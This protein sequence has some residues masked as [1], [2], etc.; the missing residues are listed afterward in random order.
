MLLGGLVSTS[1]M[2]PL[3]SADEYNKKTVLTVEEPT[4]IDEVVLQPGQ[5]VLRLLDERTD[6]HVVQIFNRDETHMI[7][8]VV[9]I[10]TERLQQTSK[11]TFAFYE[12]P[13][14]TVKALRVWYYPGDN[15]G[16]EFSYPKHLQAAAGAISAQAIA[17]A[18]AEPAPSAVEQ[19]QPQPSQ[20]AD[21]QAEP[22]TP[23]PQPT[24]QT[25]VAQNSAPSAD[26]IPVPATL[27][28]ELPQTGTY[29]PAI[30]LAGALLLAFAG[31]LRM[32]TNA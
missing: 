18:A 32:R 11:S 19:A 21:R 9:A 25:Q 30:G 20:E 13:A 29:Y 12:T 2:A 14:G 24:P 17:T 26:T 31:L 28:A 15:Y 22:L 3:A 8:T 7:E 23:A 16:Q 4:Q 5:Y 1:M 27:P 6:R 10:S